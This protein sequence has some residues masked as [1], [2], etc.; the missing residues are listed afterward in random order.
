MSDESLE[1]PSPLRNVQG[2][3][4]GGTEIAF[5][6]GVIQE[7]D[8]LKQQL[9]ACQ[10]ELRK[11]QDG[12]RPET[13]EALRKQ[14]DGSQSLAAQ[15]AYINGL[16]CELAAAQAQVE[17]LVNGQQLLMSELSKAEAQRERLR[18]LAVRFALYMTDQ[19]EDAQADFQLAIEFLREHAATKALEETS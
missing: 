18:G 16:R 7:L 3:A 10:R 5:Y 8:D 14:S 12:G 2:I 9:A 1:Q 11:W 6:Q 15:Q 17:R 13:L 4:T 19:E